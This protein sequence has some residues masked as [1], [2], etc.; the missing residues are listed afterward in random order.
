VPREQ[1]RELPESEKLLDVKTHVPRD[2]RQETRVRRDA[3]CKRISKS[4]SIATASLVRL[5]SLEV[6]DTA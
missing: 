4:I 3:N 1:F 5:L 2:P 6:D